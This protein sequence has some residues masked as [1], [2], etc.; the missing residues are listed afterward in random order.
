MKEKLYTELRELAVAIL[1]ERTIS[2]SDLKERTRQLYEQTVLL[3][4]AAQ[5]EPQVKVETIVETT[6]S[7]PEKV[8]PI[9]ESKTNEPLK[10][11]IVLDTN[12]AVEEPETVMEAPELLHELENL[13][14]DFD[15]PDFEPLEEAE[16]QP[17]ESSLEPPVTVQPTEKL[18]RS[19]NDELGKG[20]QVGLND[21]LAF[22]NQLFDGNQQDY[23]RVISQLNTIETLTEAQQFIREIIKPEYNNWD[24]KEAF[25]TRFL[26]LIER[27]F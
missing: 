18:K 15:L 25:E 24:G 21:R 6:P 16:K 27:N 19:L 20:F 7:E 26:D 11:E 9:T 17:L 4:H 22:V 10:E 2:V 12:E 23:T 13:T 3:A 1:N 5:N 14:K 8:N